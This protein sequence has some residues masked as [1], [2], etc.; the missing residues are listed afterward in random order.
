[1]VCINTV[2]AVTFVFMFRMGLINM[3]IAAFWGIGAYAS[4]LLFTKG[5]AP[6]WAALFL[7]AL[8][9]A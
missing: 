9:P 3:S 8:M 1:M 4:A 5:G 7:A 2:L 6:F